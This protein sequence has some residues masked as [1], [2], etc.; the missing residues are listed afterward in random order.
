M[1]DR[2]AKSLRVDNDDESF[3]DDVD[4][5]RRM[6]MAL[7]GKTFNE[8]DVESTLLGTGSRN[9]K[10]RKKRKTAHML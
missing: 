3:Q 5:R 8:S 9:G 7:D 2:M 6:S 4:Y 10:S 1:Q